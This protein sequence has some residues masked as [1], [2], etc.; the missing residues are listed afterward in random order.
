MIPE[1]DTILA[2]TQLAMAAE[3]SF[4][5][6]EKFDPDRFVGNPPNPFAWIPF[7]GGMMRCIGAS[8]ATMEIKIALAMLLQR[9]RLELAPKA[10]VD[11]RVMITMAPRNGLTMRVRVADKGWRAG[12]NGVTG[13]IR[14]LVELPS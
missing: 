8:F 11:H 9:F 4:P 2:S 6:A 13:K 3:S 5:D 14:D 7:G 10:L 12:A 1:G